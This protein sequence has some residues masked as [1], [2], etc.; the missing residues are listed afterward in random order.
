LER[1][2]G[3][4]IVEE[5]QEKRLERRTGKRDWIEGHKNGL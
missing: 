1:R 2:T 4:G 5:G 3:K